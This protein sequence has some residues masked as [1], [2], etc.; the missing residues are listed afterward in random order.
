VSEK[1][2]KEVDN[3]EKG[4]RCKPICEQADSNAVSTFLSVQGG[5]DYEIFND[6]RTIGFTVYSPE[7]TARHCREIFFKAPTNES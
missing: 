2:R 1:T 3:G 4:S 7:D 5:N 6:P